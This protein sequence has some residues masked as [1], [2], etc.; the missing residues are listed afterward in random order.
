MPPLFSLHGYNEGMHLIMTHEQADFDALAAM[1]GAYL[2]HEHAYPVLPRRLNRNV[3]AFLN[4]YGSDLPF[5]EIEDLPNE[6][7]TAVTLVDTQSLVTLRGVSAKTRVQVVD[8]HT[9]RENLSPHWEVK[10][11]PVGSCT[12]LFVE[13]LREHNGN[14]SPLHATL[15]LLGI[16]EDTGCLTYPSTTPRDAQAVGYLLERGAN[17]EVANKFLNPA[18]SAEQRRVYDLLLSMAETVEIGGLQVVISVADAGEMVDE[19]SSVAH[20]IRDL[21]DPDALFLLVR[22]PEG[23]RLVARSTTD[24]VDVSSIA[25]RFGGGGHG[26]AAAALIRIPE[27]ATL[28]YQESGESPMEAIKRE[29]LNVLPRFIRPAVTVSQIMSANPLTVPP[30]MTAGEALKWMERYGFEG[31]P[32][33]ED[34]KVVG[35]LNRR[36]VERAVAH[37]LSTLT[38]TS[39]MEVGSVFVYPDDPIERVRDVMAQSGWGQVPVVDRQI[40]NVVGIVTR[41][42]LLRH[43][44]GEVPV[45]G[46][47]NLARELEESIPEGRLMLIKAVAAEARRLHQAVYIV[48]GFVRDLLLGRP[49][50]DFDIVVEGDAIHLARSLEK[51]Y[52]GR[53]LPHTRFGTAKWTISPIREKLAG[54]LSE[55]NK[56]D[57][58]ELPEALDLISARR[59]FYDY[60]T[61]L[62]TVERSSIKLDLHR[63]DFTINTMAVRLDGHHF[64][65]LYDYWGGL[66]D[67]EQ[68]V[69]RVLH[70]LS[71]VDDP[72]RQ[73]RAVRFE[74]RFDFHIEHR[75]LQLMDEGRPLIR[76]LSGDRLR[77]EIN[78]ILQEEKVF[79]MLARLQELGLLAA[80][81]PALRWDEGMRPAMQHVLREPL[82]E[83]WEFPEKVANLPI[84]LALAYLVWLLPNPEGKGIAERLRLPATL[85][86]HWQDAR[87]LLENHQTIHDLAVSQVVKVLDE[88]ALPALYAVYLLIENEYLKEVLERFVHTWRLVYPQTTG[89]TLRAMGIPPGPEYREILW[90]LRAAWLDGRV[91]SVEEEQALLQCLLSSATRGDSP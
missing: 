36:A 39:L 64:G 45:P 69:V 29:I 79:A 13:G 32:V 51:R 71:F 10:I 5:V 30:K 34:G 85:Q 87:K 74:Q 19:I 1:L 8:H 88:I 73:L 57:P 25:S 35:L 81:H 49:S 90:Q 18:L 6:P 91:N 60:P 17:L 21:L 20:K 68:K 53:I 3:R 44:S 26:R 83:S 78:L 43:I 15:L 72:T 31:Y 24:R 37:K 38:V 23:I 14:L 66:R 80:I 52:G 75:T 70:S 22:T 28:P 40:G 76:H 46:R 4:L 55:K 62:P 84:R 27:G 48:G 59:E 47:R 65:D 63:R 61:A 56:I 7:V 89:D 54:M 86:E 11:E 58:Q 67:L 77:H 16:Y 41:T 33:V 50:L 42:D 2:M 12:C 82:P 9:R